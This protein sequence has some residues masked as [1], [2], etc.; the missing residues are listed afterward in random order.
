MTTNRLRAALLAALALAFATPALAQS[1]QHPDWTDGSVPTPS[2]TTPGAN[3]TT[4][5]P[6]DTYEPAD[7]T[8]SGFT[9]SQWILATN[10]T[11]DYVQTPP[12]LRERKARFT[13]EP[14]TAKQIDPILYLGTPSPVGH[15]HQGFGNYNWNPSSTW[16]TLR[17]DPKSSCGGGPLLG[18]IYWEPEM[19][20]AINGG[21]VAGIRPQV[22]SFYYIAGLLSVANDHTWLRRDFGFIGGANFGTTGQAN[23]YNDT[24]RRAQYAAA[25][26]LYPGSPDTPAGFAGWQCYR[27]SDG[28]IVAVSRVASR[29]KGQSGAAITDH[30]RH[31]KAEDG[32]DPW[33]GNCTGTT[34]S[35]GYLIGNLQAPEC[36]DRHNLRSPTGRTH[37]AYAASKADSSVQNACPRSTVNGSVVSWGKVPTLTGKAEFWH[38]GFSDYGQWYLASD[39]MNAP[40]T[41]ADPSSKDPCRAT[42][43][44]FCPGSTYHFDWIN[45]WKSSIV[46]EWQRE[47]LGISVRGVAPTNGPAECGTSQISKFRKM[48]YGGA[49]PNSALS[50]C[51][52]ILGCTN[53]V[54]GNTQRYNP[55]AAGTPVTGAVKHELGH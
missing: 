25:G 50:G 14:S 36:W 28:A 27:G 30:A 54:P 44:Y 33:G 38:T 29:M 13:C 6:A 1:Y 24:T 40:D 41:P 22:I 32:S 21:V 23:D 18:T 55:L 2:W 4:T 15:R 11:D 7:V 43:P 46:D 31:I 52:T 45:G 12:N 42:G 47:C 49:S 39:R 26:Y 16:G 8:D 34:A 48:L 3:P 10:G 9:E 37:V 35:P 5:A 51:A 17:A 53:A 20:K 19:L